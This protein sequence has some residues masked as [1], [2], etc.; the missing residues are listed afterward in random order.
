MMVGSLPLVPS[1]GFSQALP[2]ANMSDVN[3]EFPETAVSSACVASSPD[4]AQPLALPSLLSS[5]V[6]CSWAAGPISVTIVYY[7]SEPP[8]ADSSII[9]TRLYLPILTFMPTYLLLFLPA[10]PH[11]LVFLLIHFTAKSMQ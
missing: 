6:V 11:V 9:T 4:Q 10:I 3:R 8:P 5:S 1:T 7:S 2:T